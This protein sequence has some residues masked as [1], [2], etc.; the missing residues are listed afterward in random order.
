MQKRSGGEAPGRTA[1]RRLRKGFSTGTAMT[2]AAR[3]ALRTIL[4]GSAPSWVAVR[5]PLG[6]YLAVPATL[7][8]RGN[9]AARAVVIKDAGD[10]P[11]VTDKAAVAVHVTMTWANPMS[12]AGYER[13]RGGPTAQ[14]PSA[15]VVLAAGLGVGVV[16][17]PGLPVPVGEPAVNP[18]PRAMLVQ[19]L[20]EELEQSPNL[21]GF[22]SCKTCAYC[23]PVELRKP[24]GPTVR[25]SLR[26]SVP[27]PPSLTI[28]AEVSVAQGEHLARRTLNPRLGI[29]GGLSILGTTGLVKP[30]SHE[31]YE[32]TI[33]SALN[34]AKAAGCNTVV[35]STGG[36]SEKLAQR[37]LAQEPL[38]AFVQI[39][40]FFAFAVRQV[41]RMGFAHLVHSVFIGKAVKMAS[42]L[43]YTHAHKAAM[44]LK[45]LVRCGERAGAPEDLLD[46]VSRANT[47]RHAL[48]ILINAKAHAVVQE[49]A[50]EALRHSRRFA[51]SERPRIRLLLFNDDGTLLTDV[52]EPGGVEA[53]ATDGANHVP[54]P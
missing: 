36:K 15:T 46:Q 37:L 2:A 19:N 3:A 50:H 25:L 5:L 31:A 42:G 9:L 1:R 14:M 22:F 18:T 13:A 52:T 12:P 39:A 16:T 26:P 45:V 40:D 43:A 44:D 53:P 6:Y 21:K 7:E 4:S 34:V 30:V 32:E 23:A 11:D 41:A 27:V 35:L 51:G 8:F 49:V 33:V 10:D 17:K 47:A 24:T 20:E 38:E 54:K 28:H 48:Q 29:V